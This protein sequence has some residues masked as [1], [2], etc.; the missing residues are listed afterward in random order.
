MLLRAMVNQDSASTYGYISERNR[1]DDNYGKT[2]EHILQEEGG[3]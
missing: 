1:D 3:A 2:Y